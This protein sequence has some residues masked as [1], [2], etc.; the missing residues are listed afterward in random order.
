MPALP[1]LPRIAQPAPARRLVSWRRRSP[2]P[3]VGLPAPAVAG[4]FRGFLC[5]RQLGHPHPR[6]GSCRPRCAHPSCRHE[7]SSPRQ[8]NHPRW[9]RRGVAAETADPAHPTNWR[10]A[11]P[12]RCSGTDV[13]PP[14]RRN[15][16]AQS[17]S[18][19]DKASLPRA[20]ACRRALAGIHGCR[21]RPLGMSGLASAVR[22]RSA[23]QKPR[24]PSGA[25]ERQGRDAGAGPGA[26][27]PSD[28]RHL[29]GL[30]QALLRR[31]KQMSGRTHGEPRATRVTH[32]VATGPQTPALL[33]CRCSGHGGLRSSATSA[34]GHLRTSH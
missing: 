10:E 9:P 6:P 15:K 26:R 34:N 8:R 21:S 11:C 5:H 1:P 32:G 31:G 14:E 28:S 19:D 7:W 33:W 30:G 24:R 4:A 12:P 25:S 27:I 3:P 16:A 2:W 18:S 29:L 17:D 23:D 22:G 20:T 13:A